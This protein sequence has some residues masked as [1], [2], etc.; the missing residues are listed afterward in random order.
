MKKVLIVHDISC[1]GKCST[2][3]ALPIISSMALSG[4]LL[5]TALLSTHTAGFEGYTCL[6]LS[7]EMPKIVDHWRSFG[8]KFDAVYVGYL[9]S[10]QQIHYLKTVIPE[11]LTADGTFYLDPVMADNGAF[12]PAFDAQYAREMRALCEIADVIM[13]NQTEASFLYD[14][15]YQEGVKGLEQVDTLLAEAKKN[16]QSF[17][18][19]G[20]G[21][22]GEGHTGAY[23]Y[24]HKSG[25][26][27]LLQDRLVGGS[28][29]GTGDIFGSIA[30]GAHVNGA[31]L[32]AATQLSVSTLPKMIAA[33]QDNPNVLKDGLDF[34]VALGDLATF[35]QQLKQEN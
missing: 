23:Y 10:V 1:Y 15:P 14:L 20:A 22:D 12:Y 25:A 27:A 33:S 28:F 2:T 24:D 29:H 31:S 17:I 9:G 35:V 6:D 11:L 7:A 3:V 32:E 16:Q 5:P 34:E 30:V 13:P 18:L 26:H 8:L 4:V 19:T 21:A